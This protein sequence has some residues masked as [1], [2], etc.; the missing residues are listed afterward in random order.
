M[1]AYDSLKLLSIY[2]DLRVDATGVVC[3][4]LGLLG[5]D[6]YSVGCGGIVEEEELF[7]VRRQTNQ[8][9]LGLCVKNE[10]CKMTHQLNINANL[11]VFLRDTHST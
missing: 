6:L 5:T 3:H 1:E 10:R 8:S 4:Q 11:H 2:F 9:V 7:Y